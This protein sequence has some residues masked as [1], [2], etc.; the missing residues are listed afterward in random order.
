M[1]WLVLKNSLAQLK[2]FACLKMLYAPSGNDNSS[3]L[4]SQVA[5]VLPSRNGG[6][7]SIPGFE[8]ES[9]GV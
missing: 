4:V 3:H 6:Q 9:V 2:S 8:S 5:K 7:G 1:T